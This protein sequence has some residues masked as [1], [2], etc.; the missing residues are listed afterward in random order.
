M[1]SRHLSPV[2]TAVVTPGSVANA[3][4]G[5][6]APGGSKA[7]S[8]DCTRWKVRLEPLRGVDGRDLPVV[9]D[10]HPVAELV[11]LLDLVGGQEDWS[12]PRRSVWRIR[13]RMAR[14]LCA[15]RPGVG[16]SRKSSAGRWMMAIAMLRRRRMPLEKVSEL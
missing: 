16:S 9:D 6:Q 1:Y 3:P 2:L 7:T 15:S 13:S 11:G 12:F 14:V 5:P 8:T 10:G 4:G